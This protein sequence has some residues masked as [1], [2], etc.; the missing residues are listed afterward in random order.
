MIELVIILGTHIKKF[1]IA[2]YAII[3]AKCLI[4]QGSV[5]AILMCMLK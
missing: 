2:T 4:V 3:E 5:L 1:K